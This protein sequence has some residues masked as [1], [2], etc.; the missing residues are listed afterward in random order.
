[1]RYF[2]SHALLMFAIAGPGTISADAQ[3][4]ER[5]GPPPR[6]AVVPDTVAAPSPDQIRE[7][8]ELRD[9]IAEVFTAHGAPA[10]ALLYVNVDTARHGTIQF[11]EAHLPDTVIDAA[12]AV[13]G[14]YLRSLEHGRA[15]QALVRVDGEYPAVLPGRMRCRPDLTNPQALLDAVEAVSRRHPLAG[16][17]REPLVKR[18]TVV[19]VVSR[20]GRVVWVDVLEPTGD[21][22]LDSYLAGIAVH[23]RFAPASLDGIPFDA[24]TRFTHTFTIR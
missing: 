3:T 9:R 18:A 15:Y 13:V 5:R 23:L 4:P 19:M 2:L 17:V 21:A 24:R 20:E 11:L 1:M 16:K 14:E 12:T 10:S 22:Y 8:Q 6:C 7:R